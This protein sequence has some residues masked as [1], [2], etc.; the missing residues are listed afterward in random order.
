ML[1]CTPVHMWMNVC[2]F[3]VRFSCISTFLFKREVCNSKRKCSN[4]CF[5][6]GTNLSLSLVSFKDSHTPNS[7]HWL[8]RRKPFLNWGVRKYFTKL[9]ASP[10]CWY[11]SVWFCVIDRACVWGRGAAVF[12]LL[13]F[14]VKG[15]WEEQTFELQY[16]HIRVDWWTQSHC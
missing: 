8:S 10:E 14:I 2:L 4:D 3:S 9:H 5:Y 1:E 13:F 16:R 11:M 15:I 7:H 12:D 6:I